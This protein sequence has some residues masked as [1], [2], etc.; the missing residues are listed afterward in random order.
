MRTA[1]PKLLT[2]SS[3]PMKKNKDLLI[4]LIVRYL[5]TRIEQV[6]GGTSW[7]RGHEFGEC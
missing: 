5:F 2:G 6:G 1:E 7:E 3:S 4:C